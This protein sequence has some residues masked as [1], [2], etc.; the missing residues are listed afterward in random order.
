MDFLRRPPRH[1]GSIAPT[2]PIAPV[3]VRCRNPVPSQCVEQLAFLSRHAIYAPG[4]PP[5][6]KKPNDRRPIAE[7]F[8]EEEG[9]ELA[10]RAE[11]MPVEEKMGG[12]TKLAG[13]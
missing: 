2:A 8:S 6:L 12:L 11:E 4:S 9:R 1:R 3:H 7:C 10:K 13:E 5:N